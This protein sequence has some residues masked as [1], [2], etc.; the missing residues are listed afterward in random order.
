MDEIE[1]IFTGNNHLYGRTDIDNFTVSGCGSQMDSSTLNIRENLY[2]FLVKYDIKNIF[3]APCGDFWWMRNVD[4]KEIEYIGGD[5]ITKQ[6]EKLSA[7]FPNKKFVR[8]DVI[9]DKFPDVDLLFCRDCLFHLSM[10]HKIMT[11]KNFI[12]SNIKYLLMSNHPLCT[13]NQNIVTGDFGHINWQLSPWNFGEPIDILYDSNV[14]Y[15]TKEMQLYTKE[16]ILKYVKN[17]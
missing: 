13:N 16:Q 4:L 10:E 9:K 14:E 1:K 8:F 11:F 15:D 12:N 6:I 17:E 5:I 2:N 3:D 7:N